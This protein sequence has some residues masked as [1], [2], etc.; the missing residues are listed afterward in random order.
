M[1]LS[2][3]IDH[4]L[5]TMKLQSNNG[6]AILRHAGCV[7]IVSECFFSSVKALALV[8]K[9]QGVMTLTCTGFFSAKAFMVQNILWVFLKAI[10]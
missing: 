4:I 10:H 9:S 2:T 8:W 6:T 1:S 7:N 3:Q 5:L